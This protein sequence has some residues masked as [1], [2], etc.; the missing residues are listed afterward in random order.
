MNMCKSLCEPPTQGP[1]F[2]PSARFPFR[3]RALLPIPPQLLFGLEIAPR[4]RASCSCKGV[5]GEQSVP[6]SGSDRRRPRCA[7]HTRCTYCA[8]SSSRK[9]AALPRRRKGGWSRRRRWRARTL[10]FGCREAPPP[11]IRLLRYRSPRSPGAVTATRSGGTPSG[12]L[13]R[14]PRRVPA[15]ARCAR[16]AAWGVAWPTQPTARRRP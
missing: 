6:E 12:W 11:T 10:H 9:L 5:G 14:R 4:K 15:G 16:R 8:H 2:L 1:N 3:E 7:L 13:Q